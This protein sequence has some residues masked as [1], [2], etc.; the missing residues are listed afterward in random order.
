[1]AGYTPITKPSN[2]TSPRVKVRFRIERYDSHVRCGVRV[3]LRVSIGLI[4]LGHSSRHGAGDRFRLGFTLGLGDV[5]HDLCL[6]LGDMTHDLCLG[7][8][9]IT[10]DLCLGRLVTCGQG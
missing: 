4:N 6:G 8:G 2:Y 3:R 5:T 7:L 1:M 9:D 10:H